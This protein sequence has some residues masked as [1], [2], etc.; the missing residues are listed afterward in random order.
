MRRLLI[1]IAL[2][3]LA[4]PATSQTR[5]QEK[6]STTT[7]VTLASPSTIGNTMIFFVSSSTNGT[8][9]VKLGTQTALP[10][11]ACTSPVVSSLHE[12]AYHIDSISVAS[13]SVTCTS[14][15]TFNYIA[16]IEWSGTNGSPTVDYATGCA[17]GSTFSATCQTNNVNAILGLQYSPGYSSEGVSF[18]MTCSGS[19]GNP[20]FS[21]LTS[22]GFDL[23]NT[24][25]NPVG[26]GTSSGTS[27]TSMKPTI[28]C[29]TAS[30]IVVGVLGSGATQ[31][32]TSSVGQ[33]CDSVQKTSGSAILTCNIQNIGDPVFA[34]AW[35]FTACTVSTL[36]L[37][38]QNFVC[39]AGGTSLS[40]IDTGQFFSCYI[41][42]STSSGSQTVT[43][44]PG[45][46]PSEWQVSVQDVSLSNQNTLSFDTSAIDT[47]CATG[48]TY[49]TYP[50][51]S[52]TGPTITTPS[53][54]PSTTGELLV[55]FIITQHHV[56]GP[57]GSWA[58][59]SY[60]IISTDVQS[61]Q[62]VTTVNQASWISNSLSGATTADAT[63]LDNNDPFQSGILAFKYTSTAGGSVLRHRAWVIQ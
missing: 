22:T 20:T 33:V 63:V 42:A 56:T 23:A 26:W 5:V 31:Q 19:S 51:T 17:E 44:T 47:G 16:A 9:T 6:A 15:G 28:A 24:G 13:T 61:C 18:G 62:T 34:Q 48:C 14:C 38:A 59:Y 53:I 30:G 50:G 43:F 46:T 7:T 11:G 37:G 40:S 55:H 45:G 57:G 8:E 10:L 4:I 29:G 35:C 27:Q 52:P 41:L 2:L 32:L 12:C 49:G 58:C 36:T 39:P 21:N 1:L 3:C 25:S 54:T 60:Q